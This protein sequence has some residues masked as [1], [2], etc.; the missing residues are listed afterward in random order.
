LAGQEGRLDEA[1][2]AYRAAVKLA[3]T[4]RNLRNL[5]DLEARTDHVEEARGHLNQILANSRDNI[6]A[7]DSLAGIELRFGDLYQAEQRY[8]DLI[9]RFPTQRSFYAN[10]GS[11]QVLLSRYQDAN[12]T[13]HKALEL[14]SDNA[15]VNL[16]LAQAELALGHT[17]DAEGHLRKALREVEKNPVPENRMTQAQCLAHLGRKLEAVGIIVNALKKTPDDPDVLQY[18][19]QVSA[20]V[21]D[22]GAALAY[23]ERALQKGVQPRWFLLPAFNSLRNDPEFRGLMDK[24]PGAHP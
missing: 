7:L 9:A 21:G 2:A 3:P 13:F 19:A 4:W 6:F 22:H 15:L 23:V 17:Q 12:A 14:D 8:R 18:A 16:N 20:L 24:P 1:L 10:L 5:A 11:V